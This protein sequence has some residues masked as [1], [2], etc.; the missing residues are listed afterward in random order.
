VLRRAQFRGNTIRRSSMPRIGMGVSEYASAERS[1]ARDS[2][3]L[4]VRSYG[5]ARYPCF[6]A[7]GARSGDFAGATGT[8][9]GVWDHNGFR[10]VSTGLTQHIAVHT[11]AIGMSGA[12][13]AAL[14]VYP[15]APRKKAE[16]S[17]F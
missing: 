9:D 11:L 5:V 1:M 16:I 17:A 2:G 6:C 4:P 8:H 7:C 12:A 10:Y 14:L 13:C 15:Q 3:F